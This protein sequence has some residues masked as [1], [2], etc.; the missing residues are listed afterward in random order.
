MGLALEGARDDEVKSEAKAGYSEAVLS[1]L[2]EFQRSTAEYAFE[3]LYGSE[4]SARRFLIADEVGL[5]KTLV[6]AG[7]IARAI[8]HLRALDTP[9]IDIIY[10]CSNQ[11]IA[12]Q[13]VGRYQAPNLDI[14]ATSPLAERVS[15]SCRTGSTNAR[16]AR[17]PDSALTPGTSFNSASTEGVAEERIILFQDA[18]GQIW[19]DLGPNG[20]L[21]FLRRSQWTW[22][23]LSS[24]SR[25]YPEVRN[26]D[27]RHNGAD[28][29]N[30]VGGQPARRHA[31]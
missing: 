29:E 3:R 23:G 16:P 6:A 2:K 26:I 25:W 1:G 13:N 18:V 5:G 31:L 15:R 4:D 30:A 21:V 10:I 17:Q 14:D 24:T 7:V 28:S 27:T 20:R 8:D 12:R 9:R 22:S 19:G 11:A